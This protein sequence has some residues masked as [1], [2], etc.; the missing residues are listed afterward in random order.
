MS[1]HPLNLVLRFALELAALLAMGYALWSQNTGMLQPLLGIG[2]PVLAAG[3]WG[4]FRYPNDPRVP[5]VEVS[6]AVRLLLEALFFSTAVGLLVMVN[7]LTAAALL[8]GLV[9]FHYLLSYDRI[10]KM[11][12]NQPL[13][14]PFS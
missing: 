5:P 12:A 3:L 6:G 14:S 10:R 11:L 8:G 7:A 4:V 13:E 1:N 9:V 2:V